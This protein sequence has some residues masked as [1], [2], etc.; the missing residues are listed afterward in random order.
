[1][2][3]R[4]ATRPER[5]AARGILPDS[6][7][8]P[9]IC[10]DRDGFLY[11]S[12]ASRFQVVK[13]PGGPFQ[14]AFGRLATTSAL[15]RPRIADRDGHL[16]AVDASFNNVQIF[17]ERGRLLMFFGKGGDE[18]GDLLLPAKVAIDYDNL[19]Y[20]QQYVRAGFRVEYLVL[21]TSQF[22]KRRVS[23]FG[24]GREEGAR[25]PGDEEL[26]QQ[27]EERKKKALEK[28]QAGAEPPSQPVA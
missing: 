8:A 9:R 11:V 10:V 15:R 25:Y 6:S 27:V 17:N 23:I 18:A 21:V 26:L 4:A 28:P 13:R 16:Y 1:L 19:Q 22:A 2:T 24:F 5:S 3:G 20:F 12:D 7:T 14:A